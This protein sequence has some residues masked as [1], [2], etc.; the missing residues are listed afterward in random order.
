MHEFKNCY[1]PIFPPDI[2]IPDGEAHVFNNCVY[3]YGSYD[4]HAGV[5]CSEEYHVAAS[6]DLIN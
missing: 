6:P 1:N 4:T 3:V 2:C 5:Y